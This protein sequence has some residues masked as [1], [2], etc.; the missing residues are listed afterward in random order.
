[1]TIETLV[2]RYGLAALFAGAALEGEAA[3]VTGG[4]LAHQGLLPVV[5]AMA[6]AAGGSFVADQG[7]FLAGRRMRDHRWIV[8]L[9]RRPAFA[10][11]LAA[12]E[13]RPVSFIFVF[14]FLYGLR[15]I[16]PIA[17]GTSNV[18]H[19]LYVG[20]NAV[21]AIVWAICFTLVG[22]LFGEVFEDLVGRLRHDARLWWIA[23]GLLAAGALFAATRW[24]RTRR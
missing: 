5:G 1:M 24:W 18:P 20:V 19:R 14:R 22:F 23:G 7:Y 16:S 6:A 4:L 10:R 8:A 21:S 11:V 2:A 9:H 12:V 17:I 13:R 3:V 15:T